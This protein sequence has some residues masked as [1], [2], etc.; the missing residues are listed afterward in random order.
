MKGEDFMKLGAEVGTQNPVNEC[1]ATF[2][3]R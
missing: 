1:L 2:I 3:D